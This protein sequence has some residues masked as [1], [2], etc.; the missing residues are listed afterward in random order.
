MLTLV[1]RPDYLT[2]NVKLE[3]PK[4]RKKLEKVKFQQT[5]NQEIKVAASR[6]SNV[7]Q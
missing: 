1:L 4:N 2:T 6:Q 3:A 7:R 5:K